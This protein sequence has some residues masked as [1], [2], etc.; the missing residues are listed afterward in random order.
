MVNPS[1]VVTAFRSLTTYINCSRA[2]TREQIPRLCS[3]VRPVRSVF[4]GIVLCDHQHTSLRCISYEVSIKVNYKDTYTDHCFFSFDPSRSHH[5]LHGVVIS[6]IAIVPHDSRLSHSK[7]L[8]ISCNQNQD[9]NDMCTHRGNRMTPPALA[10][11]PTRGSGSAKSASSLA[12]IISHAKAASNPIYP[13]SYFSNMTLFVF[14]SHL[15]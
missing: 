15:G 5:H 3:K 11:R 10:N 14:F 8:S 9:I 12:M 6:N 7:S 13:H 2:T 4:L 1:P